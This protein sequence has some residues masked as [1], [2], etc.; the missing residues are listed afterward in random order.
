MLNHAGIHSSIGLV[1]KHRLP[2]KLMK[3]G[4]VTLFWALS[5]LGQVANPPPNRTGPLTATTL[6]TPVINTIFYASP[7]TNTISPLIAAHA[8]GN[9]KIE[10]P[11]GTYIDNLAITGSNIL[12]QGAGVNCTFIEPGTNAPVLSINASKS[13]SIQYVQLRDLTLQNTTFTSDGIDITGPPNQINDW[14]HFDNLRITGFK[15]G[16]NIIGRTIW[17]TLENVHIGESLVT[18]L[19]ANTASVINHFLWHGGQVNNSQSYGIYWNNSSPNLSFS[20]LFDHVDVEENGLSGT[21]ANCAGLYISG[22]GSGSFTNGY[23]EANCVTNPDSLGADIRIDGTYAQAFDVKSSLI[24]SQTNYSIYNTATQTS[25]LYEGNRFGGKTN[26]IKTATT[27][28][29]SYIVVGPNFF[30][31]ANNFVADASG[32]SHV[33]DMT[34]VPVTATPVEGQVVCYKAVPKT[35]AAPALGHCT[36]AVGSSGACICN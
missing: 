33:L 25:G 9:I 19:Y 6:T 28:A 3:T 22:V 14:H 35:K 4:L 10:L 11:C 23:M 24:W 30:D 21:Q 31:T 15:Y 1:T 7:G 17:T 34:T 36:S 29:L 27:H 2:N 5:A 26:D 32:N 18:G 8:S 12:I 20:I 13:D 16:I